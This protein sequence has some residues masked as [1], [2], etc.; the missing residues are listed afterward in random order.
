MRTILPRKIP[1]R[2]VTSPI[3][4][5]LLTAAIPLGTACDDDKDYSRR[6]YIEWSDTPEFDRKPDILHFSVNGSPENGCN[7]IYVRT[8][9]PLHRDRGVRR[10]R[11][12]RGSGGPAWPRTG[13]DRTRLP[14]GHLRL[15]CKAAP[16]PGTYKERKGCISLHT[17]VEYLNDFIPIVQGFPGPRRRRFRLAE[18]RL[19]QPA[20]NPRRNGDLRLDRRTE[21]QR[22][23]I[24]PAEEE[25]TAHCYGKTATS[26]WATTSDTGPTCCRPTS[27]KS[28]RTR[29][30]WSGSTP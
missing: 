19:G 20:G 13:E 2:S 21:R 30:F 9:V 10:G 28:G 17:E 4:V 1:K 23:G 12:Q 14:A 16:H 11:R 22:L 26:G 18:I 5:L 27:R 6:E 3:A 15:L 24:D 25:G 8:N 7:A 29:R